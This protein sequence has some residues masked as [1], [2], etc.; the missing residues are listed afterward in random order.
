MAEILLK[1]I[2]KK[3]DDF[4]GA[5]DINLKIEDQEFLVLLGPSGCGKTT[6][7]RMVAGLEEPSSG[8]IYIDNKLVN[9]LE[10]RDRDVAMVFQNYGLYAHLSVYE[11][12]R[13]PLRVRKIDKK[14]HH[15]KVIEAAKLVE[16]DTFLQRKPRELSGVQKQR[17]ALSRPIVERSLT[18][19]C[20]RRSLCL[21][22]RVSR[23]LW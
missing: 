2:T 20:H 11:N 8:E 15:Q 5:K 4:Y 21:F 17:V 22:D 16:L 10:P 9:N 23:R 19:I 14:T 18:V 1:N 3:W 13:F 12:I 6:T 7:M